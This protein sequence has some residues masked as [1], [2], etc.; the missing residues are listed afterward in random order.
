MSISSCRI[1]VPLSLSPTC[2]RDQAGE[3]RQFDAGGVNR[4][5][6]WME[7][8]VTGAARGGD[9]FSMVWPDCAAG[10]A[11]HR[12]PDQG[13]TVPPINIGWR[14]RSKTP[15]EANRHLTWSAVHP[16]PQATAAA[17]RR[18]PSATP[19]SSIWAWRDPVALLAH[20]DK[21]PSLLDARELTWRSVPTTRPREQADIVQR[22]E[23]AERHRCR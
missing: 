3:R 5:K 16:D 15:E 13:S 7:F 22:D 1:S 12:R 2:A 9:E 23:P 10:G 4:A 6:R 18:A 14:S 21:N 19:F 11:G 20:V 17:A 8:S